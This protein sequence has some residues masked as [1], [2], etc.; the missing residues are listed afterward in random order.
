M[1]L[2]RDPSGQT[3]LTVADAATGSPIPQRRWPAGRAARARPPRDRHRAACS[4]GRR[5]VDRSRPF[6]PRR[7]GRHPAI[8]RRALNVVRVIR[9]SERDLPRSSRGVGATSRPSSP[10]SQRTARRRLTAIGA[11]AGSPRPVSATT[12][13]RPLGPS[14]TRGRAPRLRAAHRGDRRRRARRTDRVQAPLPVAGHVVG[15]CEVVDVTDQPGW[16]G[17]AYA[18]LPLHPNEVR[19]G[20]T[21]SSPPMAR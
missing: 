12:S 21:W 20:S 1:S 17:F 5:R 8:G 13:S 6:R 18:T 4:R 14:C 10:A 11:I 9:P 7:R 3:V 16:F 19:S 2:S 15:M